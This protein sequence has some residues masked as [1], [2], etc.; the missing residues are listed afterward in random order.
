MKIHL[1]GKQKLQ[2][3]EDLLKEIS[4][5]IDVKEDEVIETSLDCSDED[6]TTDMEDISSV[7]TVKASVDHQCIICDF[8]SSWK[9]GLTIHVR[10]KHR[11]LPQLDGNSDDDECY[12]NTEHYWK[13]G[14]LGSAYQTY[15]DAIKIIDDSLF[16]EEFKKD[17][18]DAITAARKLAF[19]ESYRYFLLGVSFQYF[20]F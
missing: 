12:S 6:Q 14:W 1:K 13:T 16:E 18:K 19:G 8:K 9:N 4:K 2:K 3:L 11:S 20:Y 15:L 7:D 5:E 17:E 10:R